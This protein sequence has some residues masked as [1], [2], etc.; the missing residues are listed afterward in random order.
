M[1]GGRASGS[2]WLMAVRAW[3]SKSISFFV[4]Q[5]KGGGCASFYRDGA[6]WGYSLRFLLAVKM[7]GLGRTTGDT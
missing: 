1:K 5:G 4:S 6:W 7:N 2:C 3:Q